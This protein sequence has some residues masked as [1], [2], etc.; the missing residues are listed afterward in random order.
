MDLA[1]PKIRTGPLKAGPKI[2]KLRPKK[3]IRG[4]IPEPL[5]FRMGVEKDLQDTYPFL[6]LQSEGDP[7]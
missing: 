3:D 5:F 6:P 1:G 7:L 4:N 2:L